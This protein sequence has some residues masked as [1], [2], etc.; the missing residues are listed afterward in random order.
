MSELG[1][2]QVRLRLDDIYK[3]EVSVVLAVVDQTNARIGMFKRTPSLPAACLGLL[4]LVGNGLAA[5][6]K[7][8]HIPELGLV[9]EGISWDAARAR[10][11][12]GSIGKGKI[13]YIQEEDV[14]SSDDRVG[15]AR[16]QTLTAGETLL[17]GSTV[18]IA[19]DEK[20]G[21][22]WACQTNRSSSSLTSQAALSKIDLS[23]GDVDHNV[24]LTRF[25]RGLD[26]Y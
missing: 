14:N 11:V 9:P 4:L 6:P 12:F 13:S 25:Q 2:V 16:L 3:T 23:T 7:L 22:L 19:V 8:I 17:I 5:F 24:D 26:K 10:F 20:N 21:K 15:T 18:G 1:Y